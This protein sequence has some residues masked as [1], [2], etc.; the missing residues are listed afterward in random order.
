MLEALGMIDEQNKENQAPVKDEEPI[1]LVNVDSNIL[2]K[3]I[4]WCEEHQDAKEAEDK[5]G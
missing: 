2:K 5:P 4:A 3:V 1:P